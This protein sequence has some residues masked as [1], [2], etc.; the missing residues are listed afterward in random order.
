MAANPAAVAYEAYREHWNKCATNNTYMV[1]WS[2]ASPH[3]KEAWWKVVRALVKRGCESAE[4][5]AEEAS[6]G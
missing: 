4:Q 1:S 2:Y 6:D 3:E 5:R